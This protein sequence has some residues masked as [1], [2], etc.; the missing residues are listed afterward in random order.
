PYGTCAFDAGF[1]AGWVAEIMHDWAAQQVLL[2]DPAAALVEPQLIDAIV[3]HAQRNRE[4]EIAFSP[5]APGLAGVVLSRD[6]VERLAKMNLHAGRLLHYMPDQP[7]PDPIGGP[8]CVNVPVR[9]A[10][11]TAH[12]LF[13]SD[14]QINRLSRV[15]KDLN[16]RLIDIS[17]EQL[18]ARIEADTGID[19][20]PREVVVEL[21]TRRATQPI[22]SPLAA[23][24][25][26]RSDLPA[27]LGR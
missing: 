25:I 7:M 2:V 3:E 13:N 15:T 24:Q 12:F 22:Y 6:L 9:V 20:A 26:N 10:R 11:T 21:N 5:A 17:A 16:G 23:G 14:R 8:G 27:E 18:V 1:H 4:V 19:P